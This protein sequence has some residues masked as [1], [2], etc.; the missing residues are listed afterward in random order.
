MRVAIGA[1]HAGFELKQMIGEAL[2]HR[3]HEVI[4]VRAH[5][6][7]PVDYHVLRGGHGAVS[8]TRMIQ[9]FPD[10]LA[11]PLPALSSSTKPKCHLDFL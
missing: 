3:D 4:D 7:D 6:A 1:G 10:L 8:M 2:C 11:R 5:S 9:R